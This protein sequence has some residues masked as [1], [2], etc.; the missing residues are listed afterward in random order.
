MYLTKNV[1]ERCVMARV[2]R[3][4]QMHQENFS[5]KKFGNWSKAMRAAK[6]WI[7]KKL[8]KLPPKI[9]SKGRMTSRNHSG[10]VGVHWSPGIVK[11][12]NGNVYECPKWI[13][14]WPGCPNRGGI[15]WMEKQFEH[16]GAF[17]LAVLSRRLETINRDKVLTEFESIH[18]TKKYAEIVS[19]M[20]M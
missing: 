14:K 8:P 4:N 17:V 6:G 11:R 12:P 20:K 13:A 10:E 1:K 3:Q 7:K 9:T 16:K 5:L 2:M 19:K 18:G 15:S